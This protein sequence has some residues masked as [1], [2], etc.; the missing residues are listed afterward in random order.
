MKQ[1][2]V[3]SKIVGDL[4]MPSILRQAVGFD[5]IFNELHKN[6]GSTSN[7]YPPYNIIKK[8]DTTYSIEVAVAGFD[9]E[10]LDVEI[11]NGQLHVKGDASSRV[12][13]DGEYLHQGIALR[14]F[15]R[16]FT[17]AENVEI[18]GAVVK[19][20]LLAIDMEHIIP[21]SAKP[22]KIAITFQK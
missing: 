9:E 1:L 3:N 15:D 18:K 2:Y 20:G 4:D 5:Q 7:N 10:E 14:N 12:E 6:I 22:K 11:E 21:E 17:I 13:T 16:T 8:N 19:N